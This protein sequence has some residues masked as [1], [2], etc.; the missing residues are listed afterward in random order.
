MLR[1]A[2]YLPTDCRNV[3]LYIF[4][5]KFPSDVDGLAACDCPDPCIDSEYSAKIS[6]YKFP[7]ANFMRQKNQSG[8]HV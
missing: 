2:A 5:V 8:I 3:V 1:I 4:I 6:T 7:S